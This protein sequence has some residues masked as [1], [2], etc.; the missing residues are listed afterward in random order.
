MNLDK[1][2]DIRNSST[3][4]M[5]K[6]Y[7][8]DK[9]ENSDYILK[10]HASYE[11]TVNRSK[12]IIKTMSFSPSKEHIRDAILKDL[13]NLNKKSN[14]W[15]DAKDSN[16][17]VIPG[18]KIHPDTGKIYIQGLLHMKRSTFKMVKAKPKSEKQIIWEKLPI[19]QWRMFLFDP[20]KMDYVKGNEVEIKP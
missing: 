1:F 4:L 2:S 5:I 7:K 19:S 20:Y 3:F 17:N 18:L 9:G 16:G 11:N 8:N 6:N 10:F 15:N 14:N 12:E 13:D